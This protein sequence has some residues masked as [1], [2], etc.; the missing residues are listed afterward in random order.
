[1]MTTLVRI[2]VAGQTIEVPAD[3]ARA[4]GWGHYADGTTR[5]HYEDPRTSIMV[6]MSEGLSGLDAV[7]RAVA[8]ST[9]RAASSASTNVC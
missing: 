1:M 4:A 6:A 8:L 5:T 2:E 3:V 9:S 7:L